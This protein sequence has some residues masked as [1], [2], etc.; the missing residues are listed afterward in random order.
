MA[1]K[2]L[3]I[4]HFY[5]PIL[6][7]NIL[8][9]LICFYGVI[10][11]GSEFIALIIPIK[12]MGYACILGYQYYFSNNAHFYFRNAGFRVRM[13]YATVFGIDLLICATL[14]TAYLLLIYAL[15]S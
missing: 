9:T 10:K 2:R 6:S 5:K 15:W 1:N 3:I 11:N 7:F 12:I 13:L 14:C 4:W 8:F